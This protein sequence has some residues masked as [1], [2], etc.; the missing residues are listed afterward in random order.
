MGRESIMRSLALLNA[1]WDGTR[2]KIGRRTSESYVLQ[3]VRL[4]MG[5]A[6]QP[7]TVRAFF[8]NSKGLARGSGFAA[9]FLIAWPESTQGTRLFRAPPHAWPHLSAFHRRIRALLD[10]APNINSRGELELP[11]LDLSSQA[12]A[13]WIHFHDDVERELKPGGDMANTRDGPA[14]RRITRQDWQ[15]C[16]TSSSMAQ[17][18]ISAPSTCKQHPESSP[19]ICMKRGAF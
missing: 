7:D 18:A 4:T 13:A 2:H 10:Q 14:R 8:E 19:G 16:F 11:M 5:L 9:R 3:G 6:V 17:R 1:L 15:H 12:I